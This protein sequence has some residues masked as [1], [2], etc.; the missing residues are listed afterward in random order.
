MFSFVYLSSGQS[1]FTSARIWDPWLFFE[2]EKGSGGKNVGE[3]L[4]STIMEKK[5]RQSRYMPGVAQRVPG[6]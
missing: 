2:A 4:L 1:V 5:V 3:T 6:S